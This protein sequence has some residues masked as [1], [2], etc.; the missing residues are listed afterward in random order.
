MG[1]LTLVHRY[2]GGPVCA[3]EIVKAAC[4]RFFFAQSD[5]EADELRAVLTTD[6]ARVTCKQCLTPEERRHRRRQ[7]KQLVAWL[8]SWDS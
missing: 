7:E 1:R 3:F 5:R 8:E 6:V 2:R 4:G